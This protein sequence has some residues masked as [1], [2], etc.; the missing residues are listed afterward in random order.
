M[1]DIS[2]DE[3]LKLVSEEF[4]KTLIGECIHCGKCCVENWRFNY[5]CQLGVELKPDYKSVPDGEY[6]PCQFYD[7]VNKKCCTHE[8]KP[9]VCKY[10][11]FFESDIDLIGCP[12]YK[13]KKEK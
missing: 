9:A 11:P 1:D 10:W 3:F 2:Q 4:H 5:L 6:K 7:I 13:V 8:N 12:G